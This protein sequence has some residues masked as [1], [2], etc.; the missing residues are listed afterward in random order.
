MQRVLDDSEQLL[1]AGALCP[2]AVPS[3]PTWPSEHGT[4]WLHLQGPPIA[5]PAAALLGVYLGSQSRALTLV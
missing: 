4:A 5:A 2:M 3:G 1:R